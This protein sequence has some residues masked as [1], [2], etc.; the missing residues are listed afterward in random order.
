MRFSPGKHNAA[1]LFR[2]RKF[3]AYG[4]FL[5]YGGEKHS[6]AAFDYRTLP[7][8]TQVK[9]GGHSR[10]VSTEFPAFVSPNAVIS[11]NQHPDVAAKRFLQNQ[12]GINAGGLPQTANVVIGVP[13]AIT[14]R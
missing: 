9:R 4:R 12:D 7:Q 3:N 5:N 11:G 1:S 8:M 10:P 2:Q 13:V 14:L 6:A